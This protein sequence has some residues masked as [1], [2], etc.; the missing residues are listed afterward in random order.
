MNVQIGS[1]TSL[2]PRISDTQVLLSAI[3][4]FWNKKLIVSIIDDHL[5]VCQHAE[6]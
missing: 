4:L 2:H 6:W 1:A 5:A 3:V